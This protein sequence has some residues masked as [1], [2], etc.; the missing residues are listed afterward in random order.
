LIGELNV[1]VAAFAILT[2]A[3]LGF[4]RHFLETL[5]KVSWSYRVITPVR[6]IA[7]RLIESGRLVIFQQR[8]LTTMRVVCFASC[9]I[10]HC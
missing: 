6:T 2:T 3:S 8:A 10:W 1:F 5:G 4:Y 9:F 7:V